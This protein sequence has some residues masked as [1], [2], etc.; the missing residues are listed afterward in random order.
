MALNAKQQ[1]FGHVPEVKADPSSLRPSVLPNFKPH[2]V[3][4]VD[5]SPSLHEW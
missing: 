4:L 3:S 5:E 2:D 1:K